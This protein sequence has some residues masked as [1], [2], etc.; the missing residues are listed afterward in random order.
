MSASLART[1]FRPAAPAAAAQR[2]AA[3]TTMKTCP[4]ARFFPA[5][6]STTASSSIGTSTS[7][8]TLNAVAHVS[9]AAALVASTISFLY[10][11]DPLLF[12]HPP[13]SAIGFV[14]TKYIVAG[15]GSH[16]G[17]QGQS[18]RR[19][20]AARSAVLSGNVPA[21]AAD[22]RT[23]AART[24][25]ETPTT[26]SRI[27]ASSP[28]ASIFKQSTAPSSSAMLQQLAR[29]CSGSPHT[30]TLESFI[31]P[32][33]LQVLVVPVHP[34]KR[35]TFEQH[36][37]L[38]TQYATVQLADV[39]PDRRGDRAIF[40]ATPTSSG[41]LLFDFVTPATYAP[42][43]PLSFLSDL[44]TH[45]RVQGIIGILDASEYTTRSL[46]EAL[47]SF[48]ASLKNLPETFA[49]KIYGFGA[50]EAQ[51]EQAR[52]LKE[53]DGIVMVP[54][55]GDVGFYLKTF[56]AEFASGIL[57]EFSN[58]AAQLESRTSIPTPQEPDSVT[59]QR[60]VSRAS[61]E[62]NRSNNLPDRVSTPDSRP[63]TNGVPLLGV[64][65]P[66]Q[67]HPHIGTTGVSSAPKR[68]SLPYGTSPLAPP[69]K[70][71]LPSTSA[72]SGVSSAAQLV[73]AR[74]RKRVAGR[75]K[76]LMGDMWLLSGRPQEAIA[77]YNEAILLTKAWSDQV[78]Q[79]S[80]YE[81]VAVALVLQATRPRGSQGT[82]PPSLTPQRSESPVS[83]GSSPDTSTFLSAIPERLTLATSLYE[84]MLAPINSSRDSAGA[85]DPDRAHPLLY[86]EACLRNAKFLLAVNEARGSMPK[87]LQTLVS[88]APAESASSSS[89]EQA[90]RA[91]LNS[92]APSNTVPRSSIATWL[93]SAY[94]P[95][96]TTLAAPT[97][98]RTLS[99]IA[100]C[101]G[102]IGYRRKEA[103]VLREVAALCAETAATHAQVNSI[104]FANGFGAGDL[105]IDVG[106]GPRLN[107]T[108]GM[109]AVPIPIRPSAR[110][111]YS[112]VLNIAERACEAYGL[113][114]PSQSGADV[115]NTTNTIEH[116][117]GWPALQLGMLQDAIAVAE[118]LS[119]YQ[120]AIQFTVLA[121][122]SLAT[123]IPPDDQ[124]AL[125]HNI[126]R[127]LAAATRSGAPLSLYYW[128]PP[129]LV[130]SLEVAKLATSRQPHKYRVPDATTSSA[131]GAKPTNPFLYDPRSQSTPLREAG[132]TLVQDEVAEVF[133]TLQNPFLFELNI[134][135]LSLSTRGAK[136]A[137]ETISIVI[138]PASLQTVRLTGTPLEPGTLQMRGCN[139]QLAGCKS[140]EFLLPMT[141][142]TSETLPSSANVFDPRIERIKQ[143]GLDALPT[144][145][146]TSEGLSSDRK[147]VQDRFLECTVVPAQPLLWIRSTS[148]KHG[149]LMLYDGEMSTIR[150]SVENVSSVPVDFVLVACSDS[151]T[152][153]TRQYLSEA[154]L[155]A[156]ELYELEAD[157]VEKPVFRWLA[158]EDMTIAPGASRVLEI[159][160]RGKIGCMS[161]SIQID[162]GHRGSEARA[163]DG[164]L[165]TR[166]LSCDVLLTVHQTLV[167]HSLELSHLKSLTD[168]GYAHAR[169][170]S[171]VSLGQRGA[172]VDT[173]LEDSLRDVADGAHCLAQIA[174]TNVCGKPFEIK[175]ERHDEDDGFYLER[176]R[177]EPGSTHIMLVRLDRLHL[178]SEQLARPI[179]SLSERQ[180]IA[181]KVKR[182]EDEERL[183]RELFWYRQELLR[184]IK[185][186]WNEVGSLRSGEIG[187]QA[188]QLDLAALDI[189]RQ[190]EVHIQL[191]LAGDSAR[192]DTRR[193]RGQPAYAAAADDF[194]A[195]E[196]HVMSRS[197]LPLDLR[198]RLELIPPGS[199]PTHGALA[200]LA[201]YVVIE[202]V[203]PITLDTLQPD[204]AATASIP[205]CL[206]AQGR[207][208]FGC[209]V[210]EVNP[211]AAKK[212]RAWRARSTL[213]I[214]V[215]G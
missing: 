43:R 55:Q 214:K 63:P 90:H 131:S 60:A 9:V 167:A 44:Q 140:R 117:F 11:P 155:P 108:N 112:Q 36:V 181:A 24:L 82:H 72:A 199:P 176:K 75:E 111:D 87:A 53:S 3:A 61:G 21:A 96:L 67:S 184:R 215:D 15:A 144:L 94:S 198:L 194:L 73:D 197:A 74:A 99:D 170:A 153:A 13:R 10:H 178:T 110:T 179:P 134:A 86:A 204:K 17:P 150:I 154:E 126:P 48:Q 105:R 83:L 152:T 174:V 80:A 77:A 76:K 93:D 101:Y 114:P 56:L 130:L 191:S 201:R 124:I 206:L 166:R 121:L 40:S 135:A 58:M 57:W 143:T 156:A 45:R 52:S 136:F 180:F 88:P 193:G 62:S 210:E 69:I 41:S 28:L 12:D 91:R 185:L 146:S 78:W 70:P 115:D 2:S 133:V 207:Y 172:A 177:A 81:G 119:D 213:V 187:L 142:S 165:W 116:R 4:A 169:S 85:L 50:S 107:G 161:G 148:L 189:L 109:A 46:D 171:V 23:A 79:A 122:R 102:R 120:N 160:C 190:D 183:E 97:R 173:R 59:L 125:C 84:K 200:H 205:I 209:L 89:A 137:S 54:S 16:S 202:G 71:I 138:P 68:D 196:A 30:D 14:P 34:I 132:A 37:K 212:P 129:Q 162:Y 65:A 188:L 208:E 49:T 128:G 29:R 175:L 98:I 19:L 20:A 42:L 22:G 141:D 100:G 39:P 26:S 182:S 203:T 25:L 47:A 123:V 192:A 163:A 145:S 1:L 127:I 31:Q 35:A 5:S 147:G 7:A 151:L 149:A 18:A 139:V 95:H 92:L 211:A 27:A 8:R 33:K 51:V 195:I 6:S 158:H 66:P 64:A 32:A 164:F 103:F 38:V 159:E 118:A 168:T 113:L 157:A 106:P 186:L 104:P